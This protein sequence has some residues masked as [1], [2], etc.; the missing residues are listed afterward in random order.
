MKDN[1]INRNSFSP[2]QFEA[3]LQKCQLYLNSR[4]TVAGEPLPSH[5]NA[6]AVQNTSLDFTERAAVPGNEQRAKP[7]TFTDLLKFLENAPEGPVELDPSLLYSPRSSIHEEEDSVAGLDRGDGALFNDN[8]LFPSTAPAAPQMHQPP[9]GDENRGLNE[10]LSLSKIRALQRLEELRLEKQC[11]EMAECSFAPLTGRPPIGPRAAQIQLKVEDRLLLA[12]NQRKHDVAKR[13]QQEREEN[14]RA[15]CTFAPQLLP[16]RDRQLR[17]KPYIPLPERLN[18]EWRRKETLLEQ[19]RAK[20][21]A[22]VS[23]KP[24]I[25][26]VSVHLA[27]QRR[28]RKEPE[29]K[30]SQKIA[31][32]DEEEGG[33][34]DKIPARRGDYTKEDDFTDFQTKINP[35]SQRMLEISSRVPFDFHRRQL[36]FLKKR[37][38]N[39]H[40]LALEPIGDTKECSFKP[41]TGDTATT[42]LA[43]SEKHFD[44]AVEG[45]EERWT[46]MAFREAQQK[47][48]RLR[49]KEAE[50]RAEEATFQ[51]QLN[52]RSLYIAE[53]KAYRQQ[54][55]Q[56]LY[57]GDNSGAGGQLAEAGMTF[58]HKK[59]AEQRRR[60]ESLATRDL[61]ECTFFPNTAKPRVVGYY[62]EYEAP[63]PNAE[64]SIAVAGPDAL[65]QRIE[66][67]RRKKKHWAAQVR[68]QE[69]Q[70][71]LAECTFAPSINKARSP[72][73]TAASATTT[74]HETVAGMNRFLEVKAMAERR[75]AELDARA[76]KVFLLQPRS[77]KSRGG[78]TVPKPFKLSSETRRA[79]ERDS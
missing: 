73:A 71:Q 7:K 78:V 66:E 35:V 29:K 65:L 26:P 69:E 13:L 6:V 60:R 52:P 77:P 23:F 47:E 59:E 56:I 54:Q 40:S 53:E 9:A 3:E 28:L 33:N 21:D 8:F 49:A 16:P 5:L 63:A 58:L 74:V 17:E 1:R 22:E 2:L 27:E 51:P 38:E 42:M 30:N 19:A 61:K 12:A 68:A 34:P 36:H 50:I 32:E 76:A 44:Q 45:P 48:E 15:A 72:A 18:D 37:E 79:K 62:D 4:A 41:Y 64:L 70:K 75:Q 43:L 10:R 67:H 55:Q 46:R 14:E 31:K 24:K 25:N 39:I 20:A 11:A 57:G